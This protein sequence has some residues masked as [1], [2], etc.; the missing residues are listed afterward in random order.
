ML[1]KPLAM[2]AAARKKEMMGWGSGEEEG[3]HERERA[4]PLIPQ[5]CSL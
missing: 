2:S 4:S 1:A 5:L 3:E